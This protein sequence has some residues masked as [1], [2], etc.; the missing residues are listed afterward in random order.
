[1]QGFLPL[2]LWQQQ[3]EY[4]LYLGSRKQGLSWCT[5]LF[6][7]LIYASHSLWNKRNTYEQDRKLHGL[8]E[9]E[10]ILLK[11]AIKEH[12]RLG[13]RDLK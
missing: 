3:H 4:Y 1:M 12:Y 2:G 8:I 7:K 9:V 6:E 13:K 5:K 10:D 11:R